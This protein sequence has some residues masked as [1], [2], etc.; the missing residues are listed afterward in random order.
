MDYN[1]I[2]LSISTLRKQVDKCVGRWG[3]KKITYYSQLEPVSRMLIEE[4]GNIDEVLAICTTKAIEKTEFSEEDGESNLVMSAYDY[5]VKR[6]NGAFP[7]NGIK[8]TQCPSNAFDEKNEIEKENAIVEVA[9]YILNKKNDIK[10]LDPDANLNIWIDSQGGT[11]DVNML[12]NAIIS[13]LRL[14]GINSKGIYAVNFYNKE[15]TVINQTSTYQII[16]FVSGINEFTLYG[17][18]DQLDAYYTKVGGNKPEIVE[19]MKALAESIQLCDVERFDELL[20][21]MKDKINELERYQNQVKSDSLFTFFIEQFKNDY[22]NLL[23]DNCT[24]LDIVEWLW[25][26]KF[27]QQALTYIESQIPKEWENKKVLFFK[28]VRVDGEFLNGMIWDDYREKNNVISTVNRVKIVKY[29]IHVLN[30]DKKYLKDCTREKAIKEIMDIINSVDKQK[31]D[32]ILNYI[33]DNIVD[34]SLE[35]ILFYVE[36]YNRQKKYE[37]KIAAC[38]QSEEKV[39]ITELVLYKILK[40]ER[41]KYNHM[42]TGGKMKFITLDSCVKLFVKNGRKLYEKTFS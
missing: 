37:I 15:G 3:D 2:I 31:N 5:Y 19:T 33:R 27:Y 34:L 13:T 18:A 40:D 22:G 38:C 1:I 24:K 25:N 20:I 16:D 32:E 12:L 36:S 42:K 23:R 4:K 41:N 39:F 35:D 21:E 17:R 9:R 11:R 30:M 6:I 7:N 28:N 8:F 10:K 29:I 26:K 14:L